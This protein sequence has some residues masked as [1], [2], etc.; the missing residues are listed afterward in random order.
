MSVLPPLLRTCQ[1]AA[2]DNPQNEKL[3]SVIKRLR[4]AIAITFD[5]SRHEKS[6]DKLR[7]RNGELRALREQLAAFQQSKRPLYTFRHIRAIPPHIQSVR[8]T[9]H[10][11]HDALCSSWCCEEPAHRGHHAK[12]CL[13]AEVEG[14]VCLNLAI[15]C[16][17]LPLDPK[18]R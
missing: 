16:H 6:L 2:T 9:S 17:E 10:K 12:L 11:L 3:K 5:K 13:D 14:G 4:G 8:N 18:D 1:S 7:A 15:S